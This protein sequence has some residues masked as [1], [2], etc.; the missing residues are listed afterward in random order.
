MQAIGQ[1]R[2]GLRLPGPSHESDHELR[3]HVAG[4]NW[5]QFE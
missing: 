2:R 1:W 5:E 4:W 3:P